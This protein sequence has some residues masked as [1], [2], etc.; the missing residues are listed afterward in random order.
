MSDISFNNSKITKICYHGT[1]SAPFIVLDKTK[2]Q[3]D[4][5][6]GDAGYFGWGFYLTT[7]LEYAKTFGKNIL[8]FKVNIQNPFDFN[9]ADYDKLVEF[10]I[11]DSDKKLNSHIHD[12]M[13]FLRQVGNNK[14]LEYKN[15]NSEEV[16]E[17]CLDIYHKYKS[18]K[19]FTQEELD[20]ISS[21]L[22][23][24][25]KD[26][27]NWLNGLFFYFGREIFHYFTS[28]GFDGIIVLNGKEV[29]V[30]ETKQL[31]PVEEETEEEL[32]IV[33]DVKEDSTEWNNT[34]PIND[35]SFYEPPTINQQYN[36]VESS[37]SWKL[38][39]EQLLILKDT[40]ENAGK[41]NRWAK[42]WIEEYLAEANKQGNELSCT[43]S[44]VEGADTVRYALDFK[45]SELP[46]MRR[47]P[48]FILL[49]KYNDDFRIVKAYNTEIAQI[50]DDIVYI[51]ES[52]EKPIKED[53]ANA[54]KSL[55]KSQVLNDLLDVFGEADIN[56]LSDAVYILPNG[57]VLDTKGDS[58]VS[59]HENIS[60]YLEKK[61]N[62][63]DISKDGGSKFMNSIGA[64]RVT[65]WIPAIV[66]PSIKMT[67][68]QDDVLFSIIK[69]FSVKVSADKPLMISSEDGKQYVEYTKIGNPEEV[70]T[71]ILGYQILGILKEKLAP[72]KEHK[73]LNRLN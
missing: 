7:D 69:H 61:Y 39:I 71:A 41:L 21:L 26:I 40:L 65:P 37:V 34:Q 56:E 24:L 72:G 68:K 18:N 28:N 30:Y 58:A 46:S 16:R 20:E 62:I 67:E 14:K 63:K 60:I 11:N 33:E 47:G 55:T 29:V 25:A 4:P 48:S 23:R 73:F 15:N 50:I 9:D 27:N 31:A 8:K 54:T 70:I 66:V 13:Y 64:I 36:T 38:T 22:V 5:D 19:S 12:T 51:P 43:L 35:V 44:R 45:G 2:I 42:C 6:E 32:H 49:S 59:Q 17:Q 10:I 52:L 3:K 57:K 1:D 53:I